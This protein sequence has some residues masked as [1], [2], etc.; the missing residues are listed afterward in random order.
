MGLVVCVHEQIW[1]LALMAFGR[2]RIALGHGFVHCDRRTKDAGADVG[3][4]GEFEE[5][6]DRSVAVSKGST[7]P[8]PATINETR[9]VEIQVELEDERFG[10]CSVGG[11]CGFE[12]CN[13]KRRKLNC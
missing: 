2:C 6:L 10:Y 11:G 4:V 9:D 8:Q 5:S 7:R 13:P 1:R 3:Q 12:S